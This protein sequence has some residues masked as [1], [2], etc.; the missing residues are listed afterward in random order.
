[1][2]HTF[3][4]FARLLLALI[5]RFDTDCRVKLPS[6]NA[7]CNPKTRGFEAGSADL[8]IRAGHI[9]MISQIAS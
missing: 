6:E 4:A 7:F 5:W 8:A 2:M 9:N 3:D 1:M